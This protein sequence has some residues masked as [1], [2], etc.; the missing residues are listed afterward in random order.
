MLT[1]TPDADL[2]TT[3]QR[4]GIASAMQHLQ[5]FHDTPPAVTVIAYKH[6]LPVGH[7]ISMRLH[8]PLPVRCLGSESHVL[9]T[10][11]IPRSSIP[12]PAERLHLPINHGTYVVSARQAQHTAVHQDARHART[13]KAPQSLNAERRRS[14]THAAG[15]TRPPVRRRSLHTCPAAA[16]AWLHPPAT[17]RAPPPPASASACC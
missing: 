16:A 15:F 3:T 2:S 8:V 17:C 7:H 13:H 9:C 10:H 4:T 6:S 5:G 1:R 11:C 12:A 14:V